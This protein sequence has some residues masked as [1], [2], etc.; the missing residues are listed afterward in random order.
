[1]RNRDNGTDILRM[2]VRRQT[3]VEKCIEGENAVR[4]EPCQYLQLLCAISLPMHHRAIAGWA[5]A[6][7][8]KEFLCSLLR[9]EVTSS[10]LDL[11]A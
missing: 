3:A 8:L 11:N 9:H 10:A 2:N 4:W 5:L 7:Y 6:V 1:M